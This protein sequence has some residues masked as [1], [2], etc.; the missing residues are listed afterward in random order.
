MIVAVDWVLQCWWR[1][2][3]S[4]FHFVFR[5]CRKKKWKNSVCLEK[6]P[7]VLFVFFHLPS[8]DG[9]TSGFFS[10][11]NSSDWLNGTE[12]FSLIGKLPGR[13]LCAAPPV[14][15]RFCWCVERSF[16]AT[17]TAIVMQ[18]RAVRIPIKIPTD[19][20]GVSSN[21]LFVCVPENQRRKKTLLQFG[22]IAIFF[23]F[24]KLWRA[25]KVHFHKNKNFKFFCWNFDMEFKFNK[26]LESKTVHFCSKF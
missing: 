16:K 9:I 15:C 22:Y 7:C 8:F 6:I 23:F 14:L 17:I 24:S 11:Y 1:G 12:I 13:V 26:K 20:I 5:I 3:R 18:V 19:R 2:C 21:W 10:S 4:R 25:N